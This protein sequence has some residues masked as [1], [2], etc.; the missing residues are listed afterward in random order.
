MCD[1]VKLETGNRIATP[2]PPFWKLIWRPF[3]VVRL[4][5]NLIGRCKSHTA[6]HNKTKI[7]IMQK[8]PI[9]RPSVFQ[10]VSSNVSTVDWYISLKFELQIDFDLFKGFT[11]TNPKRE[12]KNLGGCGRHLSNRYDVKILPWMVQFEWNLVG[13]CKITCCYW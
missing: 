9:W 10:T 13:W 5:W 3:W 2:W 11:S 8:V 12:V 1:V 7:E 4:V 6:D